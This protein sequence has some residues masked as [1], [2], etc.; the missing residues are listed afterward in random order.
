MTALNVLITISNSGKLTMSFDTSTK[1]PEETNAE[2]LT[3]GQKLM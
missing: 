3:D 1:F 2:S